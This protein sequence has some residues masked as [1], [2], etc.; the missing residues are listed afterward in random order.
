MKRETEIGFMLSQLKEYLELPETG[1]VKV[2][3]SP[4]ALERVQHGPLLDFGLIASR[5]GRE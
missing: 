1:R 4:E 3:S 5:T 2:V